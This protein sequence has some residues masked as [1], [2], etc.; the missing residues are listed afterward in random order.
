APE[1]LFPAERFGPEKPEMRAIR[2]HLAH[3]ASAFWVSGF[4][5]SAIVVL[6]NRGEDC[7]GI[8]ARG[9]PDGIEVVERMPIYDSLGLYYRTAAEFSGFGGSRDESG[10]F[11]GLAAYGVPNQDVPLRIRDGRPSFDVLPPLTDA[12]PAGRREERMRQLR[13]FFT[14]HCYPY[15]AGLRQEVTAYANFAASVQ[16]SLEDAIEAVCRRAQELTGSRRLCLAGGVA[17]NCTAN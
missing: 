10:K 8:I 7:S 14:A 4:R 11:M 5:D 12:T 1:V 3:A 6:D 15:E 17:L 2:H 9:G 13:D 16:R